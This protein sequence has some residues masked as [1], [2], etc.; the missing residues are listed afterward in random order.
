MSFGL[1][2]LS[3]AA[4]PNPGRDARGSWSAG[5]GTLAV[6]QQH[7]STGNPGTGLNALIYAW[8]KMRACQVLMKFPSWLFLC[9]PPEL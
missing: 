1:A 7:F 5:Q 3:P 6:A 2:A 9:A 4:E 8:G